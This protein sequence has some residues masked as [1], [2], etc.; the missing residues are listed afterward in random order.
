MTQSKRRARIHKIRTANRRIAEA[1]LAHSRV[2]LSEQET[3]ERRI[4]LLR[5]G[6]ATGCILSDGADL[7]ASGELAMR[8]DTALT[9][10]TAS[11]NTSR[12]VNEY[13]HEQYQ[14]ALRHEAAADTL[15]EAGKRLDRRRYEHRQA[16]SRIFPVNRADTE[17]GQ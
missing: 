1:K 13:H 3:L 11:L 4:A 15:A 12:R 14:A 7:Q 10:I 8:L 16:A 6:S 5:Y 9:A 2:Q 17:E